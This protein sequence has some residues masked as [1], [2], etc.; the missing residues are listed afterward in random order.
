MSSIHS[1]GGRKRI[2]SRSS[3]DCWWLAADPQGSKF[4][5]NS[6]RSSRWGMCFSG[7]SSF[8]F[9]QLFFLESGVSVYFPYMFWSCIPFFHIFS[10][11]SHYSVHLF[12]PSS[13]LL[14]QPHLELSGVCVRVFFVV[15]KELGRVFIHLLFKHLSL[16]IQTHFC[17][18]LSP[19]AVWSFRPPSLLL[20]VSFKAWLS[21]V[22]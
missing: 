21:H 5:D 18:F 14:S 4:C 22:L 19:Q 1:T 7:M 13:I 9:S 16:K 12:I 20:K 17:W 3:D 11:L 15:R 8:F 2:L 6:G 10:N